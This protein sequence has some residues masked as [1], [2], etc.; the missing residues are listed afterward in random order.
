MPKPHLFRRNGIWHVDNTWTSPITMML[1]AHWYS[2]KH[3]R[4]SHVF[5][6]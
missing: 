5:I 1:L 3:S 6:G 2:T 4:T